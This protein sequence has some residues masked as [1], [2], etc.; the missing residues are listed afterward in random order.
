M[1]LPAE[2]ISKGEVYIIHNSA[3]A[4]EVL[5]IKDDGAGTICTPTQAEA[6][7]VWCDGVAWRG[8]VGSTA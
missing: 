1:I 2:A 4:A 6:A 5:T 3:D 7:I 8:F